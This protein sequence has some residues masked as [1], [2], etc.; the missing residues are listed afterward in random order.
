MY[1]QYLYSYPYYYP[2]RSEMNMPDMDMDQMKQMQQMMMEH[3]EANRQ[4]KQKVDVIEEQLRRMEK[5][6]K[7]Q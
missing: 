3:M 2:G 5:Y 7:M 4:I 1:P 6:M